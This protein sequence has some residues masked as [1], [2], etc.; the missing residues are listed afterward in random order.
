[1]WA[2]P[3]GSGDINDEGVVQDGYTLSWFVLGWAKDIVDGSVLV[4]A[5]NYTIRARKKR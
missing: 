2:M 4:N 1:M 3:Q 5:P